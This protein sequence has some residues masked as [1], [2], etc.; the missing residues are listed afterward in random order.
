[1]TKK[2]KDYDLDR[3]LDSVV[4]RSVLSILLSLM[5]ASIFI[6]AVGKS[7][8]LALSSLLKGSMG[9]LNA[10]ANTLNKS[11]PLIITGLAAGFAFKS[12]LLNIGIEG[13]LHI[14]A[15]FSIVTAFALPE[16]LNNGI[17]ILFCIISGMIG[18]MIW[19]TIIGVLKVKCNI[20]EVIIAILLNYIAIGITSYMINYPLQSSADLPETEQVSDGLRFA[21]LVPRTQ[22]S[23]SLIMAL[24]L[25]VI[26]YI[27]I[28]KTSLGFKLRAVG[29]NATAARA[30]GINVMFLSVM[31]MAISGMIGGLAGTA[32]ALG[33]YGKLFDGFS[34]NCGFTGLAVAV[35]ANNNPFIIILT[36]ILFGIMNSG[37]RTMSIRAGLSS[38]MIVV[39]QGLVIFFVATPGIF[40]FLKK[41]RKGNK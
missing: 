33:T 6:L 3:I 37:A 14:G 41:K 22:L 15:L 1:M 32:E 7:P 31:S 36:G 13:Q 28:N 27:I 25:V 2:L 24:V 11:V 38:D 19:G 5:I 23:T 35:L 18:G 29:D 9:N 34:G 21:T 10:I 8:V 30:G 12:G 17:G 20:N 39:I 26:V 4:L 40:S 16:C